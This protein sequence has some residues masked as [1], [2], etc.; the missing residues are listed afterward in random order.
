MVAEA[1]RGLAER[2]RDTLG[3]LSGDVDLWVASAGEDGPYLIPLSFL[4]DGAAVWVATPSASVTARNLLGSGRVRLGV[5]LTRDV[6]LIDGT[7]TGVPE[8]EVDGAVA[9]AFAARTGFDPR[10][11]KN[12][13]HYFRIVP[14][15][16]LAW[17]EANELAG[18]VLMRE[19]VW[20]EE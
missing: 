19:G 14:R 16:V 5:G 1:A 13:Y 4:W 2:V 20:L 9:E 15:R 12:A 11:E 10:A 17:R 3:R 7:V 8:G 18:R 6:T